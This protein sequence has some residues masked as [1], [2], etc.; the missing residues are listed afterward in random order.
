MLLARDARQPLAR[1]CAIC[2]LG[3]MTRHASIARE[4][5]RRIAALPETGPHGY[6][7][8]AAVPDARWPFAATWDPLQRLQ[9]LED[10]YPWE[11]PEFSPVEVRRRPAPIADPSK[12]P[13]RNRFGE[14]IRAEPP[15]APLFDDGWWREQE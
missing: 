14:V 1:L 3:R 2:A 5:L 10:R 12:S 13:K 9:S 6:V 4:A 11:V 15:L 7:V 8:R